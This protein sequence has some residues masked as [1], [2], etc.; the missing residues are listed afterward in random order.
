VLLAFDLSQVLLILI[1]LIPTRLAS[2]EPEVVW[3]KE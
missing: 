1:G 2:V 3:G